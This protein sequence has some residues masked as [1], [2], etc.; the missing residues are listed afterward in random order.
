MLLL[1]DVG[2]TNIVFAL[3]DGEKCRREKRLPTDG[4]TPQSVFENAM[5]EVLGGV[6]MEGAVLSS[7]APQVN[8]KLRAAAEQVTGQKCLTVTYDMKMNMPLNVDEPPTIGADLIAGCVGA[9]QK[10]PLPLAVAD[11]GT[12]NTVMAV[13]QKGE[14]VGGIIAPGLKMQLSA[15][16]AGTSLLPDLEVAAP[17]Q[18]IGSN[19]A[20]CLESGVVYGTAAMLD[21]VLDRMEAELGGELM[22]VATGGLSGRVIPHCRRKIALEP[23]LV[24]QGMAALFEMNQ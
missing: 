19:T 3:W 14:F 10:Y 15:L 7:V 23:D 16:G 11:L 8:D 18:C 12:A 5:A 6:A 21:G 1:L 20:D 9:M 4:D 22:V 2:N 13:N 24:P 17:K